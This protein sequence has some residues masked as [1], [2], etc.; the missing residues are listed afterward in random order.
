MA[1]LSRTV[2]YTL[3]P[4]FESIEDPDLFE[5]SKRPFTSE[6][7]VVVQFLTDYFGKDSYFS[8]ND[9][10][11]QLENYCKEPSRFNQVFTEYDVN[12]DDFSLTSPK[13]ISFEIP[14]VKNAIQ[15]IE[16]IFITL[17]NYYRMVG[18]K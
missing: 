13:I 8:I 11:E 3:D 7:Y 1:T 18:K 16:A 4:F 9:V 6:E 12:Y 14:V 15:S 17:I 10:C 5:E 2:D